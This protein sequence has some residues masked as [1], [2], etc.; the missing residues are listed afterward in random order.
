MTLKIS[1]AEPEPKINNFGS[2]TLVKILNNVI[3][4]ELVCTFSETWL[5][6]I[7]STSANR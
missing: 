6:N 1:V 7:L 3:F 4:Y 2:P 5:A